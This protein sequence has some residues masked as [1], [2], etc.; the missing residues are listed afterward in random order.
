MTRR[1][2]DF[3]RRRRM[4]PGTA[5]GALLACLALG[6]R[7]ASASGGAEPQVVIQDFRFEP[8]TLEVPAG[9]KVT[10]VNHDEEIHTVTSAQGL[11]TSPALD[12]DQRFSPR[13]ETPGTYEY[14]C[15]LHPQ[16]RGDVVVR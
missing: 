1:R 12:G 9:A 6:A 7:A 14:R 16:M 8:A 3:G 11:F 13:F 4:W 10:W 2:R 15:A 5:A